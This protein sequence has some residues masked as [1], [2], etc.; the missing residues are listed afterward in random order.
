LCSNQ[1]TIVRDYISIVD[2]DGIA[3]FETTVT[4]LNGTP[5]LADCSYTVRLS[6]P[7]TSADPTVT[8]TLQAMS[9]A[10]VVP[11]PS[12][13]IIRSTGA[14]GKSRQQTR[15]TSPSRPPLSGLYDFVLFSEQEVVK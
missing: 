12:R 13:L 14:A 15:V 9:G 2:T 3:P 6:L 7:L 4:T 10:N 11:I 1:S 8:I 5:M